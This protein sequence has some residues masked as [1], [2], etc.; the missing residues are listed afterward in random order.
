MGES[1]AG[2]I[3]IIVGFLVAVVIFGLVAGSLLSGDGTG[4]ER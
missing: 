2:D 3:L 1:V 4:T